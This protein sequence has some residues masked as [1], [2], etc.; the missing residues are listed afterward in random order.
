MDTQKISDVI[1]DM[2]SKI[3]ERER[4]FDH[5]IA[6][7]RFETVKKLLYIPFLDY[8]LEI[9]E[10]RMTT[11]ME[12]EIILHEYLE[13]E[14]LNELR[15]EDLSHEDCFLDALEQITIIPRKVPP[16][17]LGN[18]YLAWCAMFELA[19]PHTL[20]VPMPVNESL[21]T[22]MDLKNFH[23]LVRDIEAESNAWA[24]EDRYV[25]SIFKEAQVDIAQLLNIIFSNE[26]GSTLH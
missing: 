16:A 19:I 24:L 4:G 1:Y 23:T 21:G 25:E 14:S 6:R 26:K 8:A 18:Y 13:A 17:F 22:P 10:L 20:V 12:S 3:P 2:V 7:S 11:I 15:D 9:T 5:D